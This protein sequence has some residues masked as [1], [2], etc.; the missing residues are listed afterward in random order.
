[1]NVLLSEMI[2]LW[3][4]EM[5]FGPFCVSSFQN[6]SA[7]VFVLVGTGAGSSAF[8]FSREKTFCAGQCS[9][10]FRSVSWSS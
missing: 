9:V 3:L 6:I 1:M 8:M 10:N 7:A 4:P 2:V 5:G